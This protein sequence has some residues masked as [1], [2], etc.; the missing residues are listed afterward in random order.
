MT[1]QDLF[2]GAVAVSLGVLGLLASIRNWELCYRSWKTEWIKGVGGRLAVRA[3]YALLG[4]GLIS[5]GLA[6]AGGFTPN[7]SAVSPRLQPVFA[8]RQR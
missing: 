1:Y 5:L 6:I 3:I 7:K 8:D 4:L 2:V